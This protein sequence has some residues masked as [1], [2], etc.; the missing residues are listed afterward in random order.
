MRN[1]FRSKVFIKI[2][3]SI[4]SSKN[5]GHLFSCGQ[6]IENAEPIITTDEMIILKEYLFEARNRIN[7]SSGSFTDEMDT[8]FMKQNNNN[9]K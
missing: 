3:H 1:Q 4:E 6:M 8:Y 5:I 7:P 2:K 9:Q